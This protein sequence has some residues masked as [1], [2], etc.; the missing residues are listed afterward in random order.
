MFL[1]LC[2][3]SVKVQSMW[4]PGSEAEKRRNVSITSARKM[5]F[6]VGQCERVY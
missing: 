2:L 3:H 1:I 4:N 5:T 6:A